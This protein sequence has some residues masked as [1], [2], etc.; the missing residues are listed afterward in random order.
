MKLRIRAGLGLFML[1]SGLGAD[2]LGYFQQKFSAINFEKA[3]W[4]RTLEQGCYSYYAQAAGSEVQVL[5]YGTG[6]LVPFKASKKGL[7][8]TVCGDI[9]AFEEGFETGAPIAASEGKR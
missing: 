3:K 9:V 5:R 1:A 2:T 4:A 6:N 7:M 8:V